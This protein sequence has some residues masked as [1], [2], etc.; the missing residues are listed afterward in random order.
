MRFDIEEFRRMRSEIQSGK[1]T[2]SKTL[3][4]TM[5]YQVEIRSSSV[6]M[7][8][9]VFQSRRALSEKLVDLAIELKAIA[10]REAG[11]QAIYVYG[12]PSGQGSE[13]ELISVQKYSAYQE[14]WIHLSGVEFP[15]EKR[16]PE[17]LAEK[18][19]A[20]EAASE[21]EDPIDDPEVDDDPTPPGERKRQAW[22]EKSAKADSEDDPAE[23]DSEKKPT[24]K[25]PVA[26]KSWDLPTTVMG[27]SKENP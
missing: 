11:H 7:Q 9:M 27:A 10:E 20:A 3:D 25:K 21:K 16:N 24:K 19:V 6:T 5:E 26:R 15:Y 18:L 4:R 23:P 17:A 14:A 1:S 12:R 13:F 22:R 2:L 8:P